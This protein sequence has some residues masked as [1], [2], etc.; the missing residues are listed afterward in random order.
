MLLVSILGIPLLGAAA[1]LR[2]R[3]RSASIP[4]IASSIVLVLGAW[5]LRGVLGSGDL[6]FKLSLSGPFTP[7]LRAD[8]LSMIFVL[9][10]AFLWWVVSIYSP[11]Y[12]KVEGRLRTFAIVSLLT[13]T[14]VMG[15]FLAGDFLTLLLFFELMTIASYFWVV[16]RWDKEAVRA[17]YFYLF[18]SIVGGLFVALG[19]VLIGSTAGGVPAVGAGP[20][21]ALEP[22]LFHYGIAALVA[23]FGIKAGM[24]PLHLWLPHAHSTA[25][26]PASAL[27]SG[28]LIKIG[29]YGLIRTSELAGW[30]AAPWLGPALTIL[31]VCTMLTG[32]AAALLQSDAKRLLAYHSVSQMGYIILGRGIGL[33][34]G[35]E[36][37]LGLLGAVYHI[38]NHALFKAALFLGVGVIYI[39]TRETSLYRLGGLWRDF[40]ITAFLMLLA[41]LGITGAPG[42][43]G[44]ASKTLLHHAVSA[45][46]K[47]G[48]P[49]MV[50]VERLFLLVGVGTAASF[51]KLYYLMFLGKAAE[52][53]TASVSDGGSKR[54][55]I[56]MGLLALAMVVIGLRPELL[57]QALIVPAVEALGMKTAA[58]AAAGI[59]FWDSGD[60]IG[61]LVTLC[62][63]MA[64][65]WAGLKTSAFSW[66]PPAWL[67]LEGVGSLAVRGLSAAFHTGETAY[68]RVR[69]YIF[70]AGR[71]MRSRLLEG[72]RRVDHSRSVFL[73]SLRLKGIGADLALVMAALAFL[74]VWRLSSSILRASAA[75]LAA[76]M[77]MLR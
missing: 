15:V 55:H 69:A 12:M 36:G 33:S 21:N 50:W 74:V 61:M 39:H 75:P 5:G 9:T 24:V 54:L 73:G 48:Q 53:A 6:T 34:L 4:F 47:T 59:G 28:L 65:C 72:C 63:G 60:I 18:F 22:G 29:A 19:L 10:A 66:Q 8:A 57:L 13:L 3:N 26:T 37:G 20:L 30:G 71:T 56:S 45:A 62:F 16:H 70:G 44:Y 38:V 64:V 77:G 67:T 42:L 1:L 14:A 46:A 52:P 31:G 32:V 17:G 11:V 35:M 2:L 27:L 41:V 7:S 23:G 40:P 43:N 51:T 76:L 49:W 68:R 25:P 58:D